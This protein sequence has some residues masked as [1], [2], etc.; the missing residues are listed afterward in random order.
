M[1]NNGLEIIK[2]NRLIIRAANSRY[3]KQYLDFKI[4]NKSFHKEWSPTF[5]EKFY[6]ISEINKLLEKWSNE[7]LNEQ[8]F[9][10]LIFNSN[11]NNHVIGAFAFSNIVHGAF[12]S[13]HLGYSMDQDH[14]KKG[15]MTEALIG[16]INFFFNEK[17]LHRIEAN[18]IPRNKASI[19]LLKNLKFQEEGLARKYL[20]INGKWEDHIHFTL[21]NE[22]IE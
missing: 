7:F 3:S 6:S 12:L 21:L 5:P 8:S 2:T 11:E 4:R 17:K 22:A 18:V 13:S 16:G 20:K 19:R 15:V 9:R 10:F 1:S 14:I